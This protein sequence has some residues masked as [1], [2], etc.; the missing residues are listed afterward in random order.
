M[1]K[2]KKFIKGALLVLLAF[3]AV[4]GISVTLS[5]FVNAN[6]ADVS[7]SVKSNN[8]DGESCENTALLEDYFAQSSDFSLK[9]N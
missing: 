4:L 6:K 5:S 7:K 2:R 9:N 3:V 1:I 8:S